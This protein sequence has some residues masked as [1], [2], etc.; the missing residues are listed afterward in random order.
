MIIFL[1]TTRKKVVIFIHQYL[2]INSIRWNSNTCMKETFIFVSFTDHVE[3][4]FFVAAQKHFHR[5]P[6]STQHLINKNPKQQRHVQ[7]LNWL[8]YFY[9]LLTYFWHDINSCKM[10]VVLRI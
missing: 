10:F 3:T 2:Q 1:Y 9:I 8:R 6:H 5:S 7:Q 4:S